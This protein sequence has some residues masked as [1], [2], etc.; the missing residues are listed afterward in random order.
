MTAR[1]Q[2]PKNRRIPI[3]SPRLMREMAVL[4]ISVALMAAVL[5][6][7]VFTEEHRPLGPTEDALA[8]AREAL[9]PA[10]PTSQTVRDV[11]AMLD[12]DH[13]PRRWGDP[14]WVRVELLSLRRQIRRLAVNRGRG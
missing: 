14:T 8:W 12:L 2:S 11:V 6:Q 13:R 7:E 4:R 3:V 9:E 10:A 1:R 5:R